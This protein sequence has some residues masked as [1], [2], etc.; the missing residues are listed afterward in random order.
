MENAGVYQILKLKEEKLNIYNSSNNNE[1]DNN[2]INK[3]SL[4]N[5]VIID[6]FLN[7]IN[8]G[9]NNNNGAFIHDFSNDD[10]ESNININN[11]C[12]PIPSFLLCLQ[13]TKE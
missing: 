10:D 11:E 4:V 1:E 7:T 13:K 6:N 2:K 9:Y 5:D 3:L 8:I 12:E